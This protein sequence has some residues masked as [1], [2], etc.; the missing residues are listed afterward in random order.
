MDP[1]RLIGSLI[2][3]MLGGRKK[4][5]SRTLRHLTRGTGSLVTGSTLLTAAGLA[6]GAYEVM[7]RQKASGSSPGGLGSDP[8]PTGGG[9]LPP[10]LTGTGTPPPLPGAAR[11]AAPAVGAPGAAGPPPPL[12]GAAARFPPEVVRLVRL[13]ISA[14]R[15]DGTLGPDELELLMARAREAGAEQLVEAEIN[16]RRPL[17][18]IVAGVS[19]PRQKEELYALAYALVRA[20][21]QVTGAERVY[22]AQL[23]HVL[24]LGDDVTSRLESETD[25]G[26]DAAE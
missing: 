14:A 2:G 12:P 26:I 23:A 5:S 16:A 7:S 8:A 21:E 20:D 1:E 18:E 9:A 24:G 17:A 6:W 15:A 11:A 10:P 25:A 13:A 22:L 19:D 4:K 3:G